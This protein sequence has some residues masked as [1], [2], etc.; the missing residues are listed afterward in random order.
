MNEQTTIVT[1]EHIDLTLMT[2]HMIENSPKNDFGRNRRKSF[3]RPVKYNTSTDLR[4]Q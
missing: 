4:L 2:N 3:V 1:N